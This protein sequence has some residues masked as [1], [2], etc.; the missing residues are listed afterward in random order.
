MTA[1]VIRVY[2]VEDVVRHAR[3]DAGVEGTGS[4]TGDDTNTRWMCVE[5]SSDGVVDHHSMGECVV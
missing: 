2:G 1:I 4:L 3:A 5:V